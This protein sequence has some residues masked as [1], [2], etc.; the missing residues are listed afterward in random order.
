MAACLLLFASIFNVTEIPPGFK[1]LVDGHGHGF[2][3]VPGQLSKWSFDCHMLVA[4]VAPCP[5]KALAQLTTLHVVAMVQAFF[6]GLPS[7]DTSPRA[8]P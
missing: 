1:A 7:G 5:G 2:R 3:V 6:I 4:A 8:Q